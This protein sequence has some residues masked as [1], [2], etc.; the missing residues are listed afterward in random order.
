VAVKETS[1]KLPIE[2]LAPARNV[3][4][5]K[6]AINHG[7]DALYIGA[8]HF[9]ARAA[10]G[11][12]SEEIG[13]LIRY[14]HVYRARVYATLNTILF[15]H[16]LDDVRQ[17]IQELYESGIDGIIIQDM[18]ILEFDLPPVQ[19]IASTQTHNN[20]VEKVLFLEKVGFTRII[21]ARE[22]SLQE[23]KTIRSQTNA[24]LE[25]FVHGALC[26]S[27][28]GQCYMSQAICNRSGNRGACAQPCRSVYNLLDKDQNILQ[29]DKHLL[30]LKDLQ[31]SDYLEDMID[32]GISSFKIEGRLK[33]TG[34]VKNIVSHYRQKLDFILEHKSG[35]RKSSSGKPLIS[36]QPD[37]QRTFNRGYTPLL[38][39][40]R[41]EKIASVLTQKSLGKKIGIITAVGKNWFKIAGEKLSNGDGI[42]FFQAQGLGGTLVNSVE[43][44][45]IFPR[46]MDG[47]TDGLEIFRNHDHEFEKILDNSNHLRK[48]EVEMILT[49]THTG[50]RLQMQDEDGVCADMSTDTGK[51]IADKQ[52]V[53]RESIIQQLGKLGDTKFICRKVSLELSFVPFLR[54]SVVNHM[55]RSV[56]EK[57]EE[58]RLH[59][60]DR[61]VFYHQVSEIPYPQKRVTYLGNVSNRQAQKF[62]E[63]HGVEKIDPAFELVVPAGEAVVMTTKHCIRYHLDACPIHQKSTK[64]LNEPL[65]LQDNHHKYRLDFDCKQCQMNLIL[66]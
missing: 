30:S 51:I 22:L 63:R 62:Y 33:D 57:L 6:A 45:K 19:L 55:R 29:K 38:L 16:E 20:S 35:Y 27:F 42:C 11:N 56:A 2:L 1:G 5:G 9:G 24:E 15:D 32:A 13:E 54:T 50:Y 53:A 44:D 41:T 10:A 34:Y 21:L 60:F 59:S 52:D 40:G 31:L 46:Q 61:P 26:V 36:F 14:A 49:E 3:D 25:S 28:S 47:L 8:S 12:S 65:F 58:I 23:I 66:L 43:G 4:F 17:L 7:A 39:N 48:I 18:G 64:K 37:P